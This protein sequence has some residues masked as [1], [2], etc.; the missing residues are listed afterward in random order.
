MSECGREGKHGRE[1]HRRKQHHRIKQI[2][3]TV[4]DLAIPLPMVVDTVTRIRNAAHI[5]RTV[6]NS[7]MWSRMI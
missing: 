2:G 3:V 4:T 7:G 5:E 6:P 1:Q